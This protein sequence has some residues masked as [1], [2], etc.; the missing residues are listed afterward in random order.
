[1]EYPINTELL[2]VEEF[3]SL[4]KIKMQLVPSLC[5]GHKETV[6]WYGE[7]SGYILEI[8]LL[9]KTIY[10]KSICTFTPTF[11]IDK[12]DA[13]LIENTEKTILSKELNVNLNE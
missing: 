5:K 12:I 9:S 2:T 3:N 11:G 7:K 13:Q 4:E 10:A 8:K 6:I 1:M